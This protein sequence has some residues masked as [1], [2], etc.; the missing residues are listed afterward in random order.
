M[1]DDALH[2][3]AEVTEGY[4]GGDEMPLG[5]YAQLIAIFGGTVGVL[6]VAMALF[7]RRLP[8]RMPAADVLLLAVGTHKL[9]R[10]LTVD[11]VTSPLRAPLTEYV[12]TAGTGEVTERSRGRGLQ[13]AA[14]DLLTCPWC[15]DWWVATGLGGAY[16]IAPRLTRFVATLLTAVTAADFLHLAYEK[17]KAASG[18]TP[19]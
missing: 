17:T 8:D 7:G 18:Q 1:T 4:G 3:A 12:G 19:K 9:S 10:L 16:L 13:R 2:R 5:G 11:F 14:G 15:F 6:A